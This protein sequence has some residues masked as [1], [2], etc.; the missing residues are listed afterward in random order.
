MN[1]E[2]P[3]AAGFL[4]G[5][6]ACGKTAVAQWLA[7]RHGYEILSADSMLVYRG[8]DIG[9]A[10]PSVGERARVA[11]HGLDLTT[12]DLPFSVWEYSRH[13][14]GVLAEAS[15]QGRKVIVA[16][17]TGLYVKCLTHGLRAA[18]APDPATRERWERVEREQGI[19]ALQEALK[20]RSP[21]V[22]ESLRD[23]ANVRRLLRALEVA[24]DG[25][26]GLPAT[27][28][29]AAPSAP[30]A[31][32]RRTA[33][34]LKSRVESRVARMYAAGFIDEVEGILRQY[35]VLSET[36]RQ[37][38]GYAEVMDCL[39]GR[40]SPAEARQRTVI[41]TRQL[42]KRQLTW[43]RHQAEVRWI[44]VPP[45]MDTAAI[46]ERVMEHWDACGLTRIRS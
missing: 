12:P 10:K 6:T 15:A 17:G 7:E 20:A 35:P 42:A 39:A 2:A 26:K 16:G 43:F 5:P 1:A 3:F 41:R 13:A 34:D 8:M 24:G 4:V 31:G 40:C 28:A 46:A 29:E 25:A 9:T 32:I 45:G 30:L 36:A 33:D 14:H 11:Y 44:D 27:W 37:A 21:E 23:K 19:G 18:P 22:Y 38:I